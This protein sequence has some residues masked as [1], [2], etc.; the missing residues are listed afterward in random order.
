M[1]MM[2]SEPGRGQAGVLPSG[3]AVARAPTVPF[4]TALLAVGVTLLY[5]PIDFPIT[6]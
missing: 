5:S 2:P 1:S 6:R 3:L 4:R